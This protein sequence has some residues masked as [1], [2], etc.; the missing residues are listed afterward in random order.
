MA[1][2]LTR[3][4]ED[5]GFGFTPEVAAGLL[6]GLER[7]FTLRFPDAQVEYRLFRDLQ[8]ELKT[9]G[10]QGPRHPDR[11]SVPEPRHSHSAYPKRQAFCRG[12]GRRSHRGDHA[13]RNPRILESTFGRFSTVARAYFDCLHILLLNSW[14]R[15]RSGMV[16]HTSANSCLLACV[17]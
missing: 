12:R 7:T 2:F 3:P 11:G 16:G 14:L 8:R 15:S 5:N 10:K 6:D 1:N 17:Q 4:A 13:G 9:S